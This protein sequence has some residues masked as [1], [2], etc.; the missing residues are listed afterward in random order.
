ML[1][2]IVLIYIALSLSGCT[3]INAVIAMNKSTD[4]FIPLEAD[5][6]VVYETGAESVA[7]TVAGKLAFALHTVEQQQFR[8]FTTPVVIHV[9]SSVES[10]TAYCVQSRAVGCVLNERLFLSPNVKHRVKAVLTHE[11]SHLHMEQQLGML[12]WYSNVPVW[13]KE[14][15]AVYV[16]GGG[17][18]ERVSADAAIKAIN[19][20]LSFT[21]DAHGSLISHKSASSYGLKP[22]MFYRQA[23]L[24]VEYLH[25]KD[26]TGFKELLLALADGDAFD[27]AVSTAYGMPLRGIWQNFIQQLKA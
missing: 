15:L 5:S 6:R 12:A 2:N 10:F 1:R 8:K 3:I 11:L 18:A 22:H 7:K 23:S 20:G 26:I 9:C 17:G 24:F 14:G 21:P 16:S 4:H 27:H 13:F 25:K 19:L